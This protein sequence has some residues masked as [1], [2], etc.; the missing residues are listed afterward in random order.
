VLWPPRPAPAQSDP[1]PSPLD[2]NNATVEQLDR[3]PGIGPLR[4]AAILRIRERNGP[5][6]SVEE[7]RAVPRLSAKLFEQLRVLVTID[8]S[9]SKPDSA[10]NPVFPP[11]GPKRH[12]PA[13][14]RQAVPA[15]KSAAQP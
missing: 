4:A 10:P 3:L 5:F 2:V 12:V 7:L 14:A 1:Q 6:R 8:P 13:G 15:L 9:P 11:D